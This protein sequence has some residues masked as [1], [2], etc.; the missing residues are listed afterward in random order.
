MTLLEVNRGC[1]RGCRFCS[2]C[3][4]YRPYRNRTLES[5]TRAAEEGL[6]RGTRIGLTGAA[7]SDH[8]GLE[9]LCE[10]IVARGGTFS[11]ASVR[12]DNVTER[13]GRS[14]KMAGLKTVALAPETGSERLRTLIHKGITGEDIFRATEV[15]LENDLVNFR[16]YFLIG[17][18][19][20]TDEDVEAIVSLTRRIKHR[21]LQSAKS[22]RRLG[23]ITLSINGLVPKPS[24]PFQWAPFEDV[25]VLNQ[26][27]KVIKN[28]LKREANVEV[29]H[30][31]PKWGYVQSLLSRGD[32]R[33]GKI[34]LAA[35]QGGGDWRRAFRQ[36]N[37]NP[38]F[39][40]YRQ[41][42]R[43]EIFPW[44]FIDH[45]VSK[46]WLW[47]QYMRAVRR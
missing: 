44:D 35:H 31:V 30:D 40:V 13:L 4:L 45:G 9:D 22:T 1:P 32:R 43:E 34:L 8:P 20:E 42:D 17:I 15:L 3:L 23:R 7:V 10:F 21:M 26:K 25:N 24:T 11:L 12:L 28:G 6:R 2:A 5:L 33:V 16:L 14:L 46:D 18:P 27:L 36:V 47:E 39:Y 19:T 38:D 37:I 41:R 29:T